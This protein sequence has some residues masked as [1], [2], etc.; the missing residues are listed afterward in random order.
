[1]PSIATSRVTASDVCS[2]VSETTAD[3]PWQSVVKDSPVL[4]EPELVQVPV[5]SPKRSPLRD[6]PALPLI[7]MIWFTVV[8]LRAAVELTLELG[9]AIFALVRW[10]V[11]R[12]QAQQPSE[13]NAAP[14]LEPL[15]TAG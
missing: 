15:A 12:Y 4:T 5:T 3:D 9:V 13:M 7:L 8:V 11:H 14:R 1:M 10:A 2:S 6:S